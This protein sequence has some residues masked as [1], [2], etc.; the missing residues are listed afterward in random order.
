MPETAESRR[1]M[2]QAI[3]REQ[4]ADN[5]LPNLLKLTFA[6]SQQVGKRE[7]NISGLQVLLALATAFCLTSGFVW[8]FVRHWLFAP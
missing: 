5:L 7:I 2:K 4:A 8:A 3:V 1:K 6:P